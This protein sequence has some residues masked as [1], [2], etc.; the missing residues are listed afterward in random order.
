[1]KVVQINTAVNTGST[2]RITEEI[3]QTILANGGESFVAYGRKGGNTKSVSIQIGTSIDHSIHGLRT[4]LFDTHGFGS[5]SATIQLVKQL[6]LIR[7]DIIHLHNLHG[8]YLHVGV[9]FSYLK[10]QQ[11]PVVWTLHDCW[12]FT[13]HC[14]YFDS[15]NCEKWKT[16]CFAC[17]KKK[18]YPTSYWIDNSKS[19]YQLKNELFNLPQTVQIVTPSKWLASHVQDSFLKSNPITVI[20]NGVDTKLFKPID[21]SKIGESYHL[22]GKNI[23]LGCASIWD[24]RKGLDDF[25][26]LH[27]YLQP[28][29]II[30]L[31]GL[32]QQ[33]IKSLPVGIIGI[34]RTENI[35]EL[36]A[37]YS[38]AD[39]FVNPTWQ[40]NF[41]TTNLEALAC[42][43]AVITYNTGGSPEAI[44][45]ATGFVI[46]KGNVQSLADAVNTVL[47]NGKNHYR[48]NC[49]KRA[50]HL[51]NKNDRYGD[52]LKLYESLLTQA[53]KN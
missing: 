33:Q 38:T 27:Q 6:Q 16:G 26:A 18:A 37:L 24:K 30:V 36:A 10:Q 21:A 29:Q 8:Y 23:I 49:R 39:V 45:E 47:E 2:G 14:T 1:L 7:P 31:V 20:H 44:D 12:S 43:T 42:G 35:Q 9:L 40:D 53:V 51:F 32:N 28:N 34:Q 25:I 52:Y 48:S 13:G 15:V 46:K 22:A 50:E 17:P 3:G 11:I 41:P 4:R 19:N 5:K